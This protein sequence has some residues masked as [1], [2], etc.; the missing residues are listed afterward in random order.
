M[1]GHVRRGIIGAA[2][3]HTRRRRIVRRNQERVPRLNEVVEEESAQ[4]TDAERDEH[5]REI[6]ISGIGDE[7]SMEGRRSWSRGRVY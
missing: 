5:C 1:L 4:Q 2:R 7:F 3:P 6:Q